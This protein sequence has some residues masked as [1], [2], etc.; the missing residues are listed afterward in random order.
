MKALLKPL[1]AVVAA[2]ALAQTLPAAELGDAAAPLKISK[3]IKGKPVDLAAA[4]G[5]QIVVVEFWATWCP[6]CRTSIPHLTEMQKKFKDVVFVGVTGEDAATVKPFVD[7]MGAKMDYVVAV[8]DNDK[9]SKGYME[10]YG[11]DGIPHA[12]IVNKEGKV[13]WQ[14]HP[15]DKLDKALESVISGKHETPKQK[16]AGAS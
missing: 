10:A 11:I 16:K 15:M 6:P 5:K 9:T 4:K 7:K 8:D 3:W 13:V 14:G 12:F 1:I 2:F